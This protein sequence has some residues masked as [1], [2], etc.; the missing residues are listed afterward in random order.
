METTPTVQPGRRRLTEWHLYSGLTVILGVLPFLIYAAAWVFRFLPGDNYG[1]NYSPWPGSA[2]ERSY[3]FCMILLVP[4]ALF[5]LLTCIA[6]LSIRWSWRLL[7]LG[8]GLTAL[9][10]FLLAAQ[11]IFQQLLRTT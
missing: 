2:Y 1:G 11:Y 9:Q 7:L 5:S 6:Q 8:I 3:I 4:L 10:I